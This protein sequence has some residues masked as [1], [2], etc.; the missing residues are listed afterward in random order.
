[1]I[2]HEGQHVERLVLEPVLSS[3]RPQ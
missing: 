3:A 1:V 2:F